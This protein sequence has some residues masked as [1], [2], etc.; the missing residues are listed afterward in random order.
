MTLLLC[1]ISF[2]EVTARKIIYYG[3]LVGNVLSVAMFAAFVH[4][5]SEWNA[6]NI[7]F[8]AVLSSF[9]LFRIIVLVLNPIWWVWKIVALT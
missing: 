1:G 2:G 8:V 3:L 5:M 7:A 6:V 4:S 9:S